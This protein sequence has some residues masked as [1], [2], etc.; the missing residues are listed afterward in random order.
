[1]E[2]NFV[3]FSNIP[4]YDLYK[5]LL[6][7]SVENVDSGT[8]KKFHHQNAPEYLEKRQRLRRKSGGNILSDI[9]KPQRGRKNQKRNESESPRTVSSS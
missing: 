4:M 8:P 9:L 3:K 6:L 2:K 7:F 5:N 1:V